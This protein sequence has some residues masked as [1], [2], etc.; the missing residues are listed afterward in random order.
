[1]T[2]EDCVTYCGDTSNLIHTDLAFAQNAGYRA[3][4][5]GGSHG[6]RYM[7]QALWAAHQPRTI[8]MDILFRRPI[9]WDDAFDV[10]VD[11]A[12]GDWRALCTE[13]NGKVMSE[14]KINAMA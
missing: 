7:T 2:P 14:L 1:M 12:G 9:F 6:V 4:I 10:R 8:D 3:P 13:R 11:D 5:V